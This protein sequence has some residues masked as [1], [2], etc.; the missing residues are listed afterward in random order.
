[1]TTEQERVSSLVH[2]VIDHYQDR[3]IHHLSNE[4]TD[5]SISIGDEI[6]E[7]I[8]DLDSEQIFYYVEEDLKE[9]Y[10]EAIKSRRN[11]RKR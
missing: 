7:W 2:S 10:R 9:L 3:F 5:N 1:M 4:N 8:R 6:L 11:K